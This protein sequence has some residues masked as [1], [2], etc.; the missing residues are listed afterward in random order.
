[1]PAWKL[2]GTLPRSR[3]KED[4]RNQSLGGWNPWQYSWSAWEEPEIV[5]PDPANPAKSRHIPRYHSQSPTGTIR[6][7]V[8]IV[9]CHYRFYVPSSI[10]EEGAF[11]ASEPR[12]EGYWRSSYEEAI[13]LPWP[14]PA[15]EWTGRD[16][17]IAFLMRAE[18]IAEKIQYR[19]YSHC[20]LCHCLNGSKSLRLAEWDWPEGFKHYV[21]EHS[22][23]PSADFEEFLLSR[24]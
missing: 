4:I 8:D 19:G 18:E 11:E 5:V 12:Y 20:R 24:A 13:D 2:L 7:A 23:R 22:V 3:T 10:E 9:D 21:A 15:S 14:A 6:F 16:I 1:M 17:F